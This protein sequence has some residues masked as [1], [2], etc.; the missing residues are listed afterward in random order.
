MK[1][2]FAAA[3]AVLPAIS[4]PAL[5]NTT[6]VSCPGYVIA[7]QDAIAIQAQVQTG[8][9]TAFER[10]VCERSADLADDLD[11]TSVIPVFIEELGVASRVGIFPTDDE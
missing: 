4:A 11:R 7:L 6:A 10:I 1:R 9:Q 8:S 3:V 2:T 5:A